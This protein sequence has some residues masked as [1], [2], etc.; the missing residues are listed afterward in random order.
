MV[1]HLFSLNSPYALSLSLSSSARLSV[2]RPFFS[3]AASLLLLSLSRVGH[4]AS[5]LFE[6]HLPLGTEHNTPVLLSLSFLLSLALAVPVLRSFVRSFFLSFSS[7][8]L[9]LSAT[10]P[11]RRDGYVRA[12]T[13]SI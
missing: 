2:R 11:Q 5:R 4:G 6:G 3:L 12:R 8:F 13:A 9:R 1:A 7:L 10:P